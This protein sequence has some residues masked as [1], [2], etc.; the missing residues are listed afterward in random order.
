MKSSED[1]NITRR[2]FVRGTTT[3]IAAVSTSSFSA[4]YAKDKP[5]CQ[6]TKCQAKNAWKMKLATS[7]V[8]FDRLPI[9]QVCQRAEQL[10]LAELKNQ[11]QRA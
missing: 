4:V 6:T 1:R 7:S 2:D 3:A 8:M 11:A 5:K 9:E 10:G